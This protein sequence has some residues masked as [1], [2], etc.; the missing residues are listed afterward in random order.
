MPTKGQRADVL[1]AGVDERIPPSPS[2]GFL[3]THPRWRC[4]PVGGG[5]NSLGTKNGWRNPSWKEQVVKHSGKGTLCSGLAW[6]A[7]LLSEE[8]SNW[9]FA[10]PPVSKQEHSGRGNVGGSFAIAFL[11]PRTVSASHSHRL[12]FISA[13]R[14]GCEQSQAL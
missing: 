9:G 6:A 7:F 10:R 8:P 14:D 3:W 13:F 5:R 4:W 2:T 12:A 1:G 11:P